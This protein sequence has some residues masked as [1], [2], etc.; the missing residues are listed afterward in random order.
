MYK[1]FVVKSL[2][3]VGK[4]LPLQV[5]VATLVSSKQ[6]PLCY[7]LLW[8]NSLRLAGFIHHS[9]QVSK[10]QPKGRS[11]NKLPGRADYLPYLTWRPP[12]PFTWPDTL[13]VTA[14]VYQGLLSCCF[15]SALHDLGY[16]SDRSLKLLLHLSEICLLALSLFL[17][18][19]FYCH[20]DLVCGPYCNIQH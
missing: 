1:Q 11:A 9:R 19:V 8:T 16:L 13:P 2:P 4:M 12:K 3:S 7:Y 10:P 14:L 5:Q 6:A 15:Y 20:K 18:D 17:K